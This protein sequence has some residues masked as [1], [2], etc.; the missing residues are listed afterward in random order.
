MSE[1]KYVFFDIETLSTRK[2][3][4]VLSFGATIVDPTKY[5]TFEQIVSKG[6]SIKFDAAQQTELGRHIDKE[7]LEWWSEQGNAAQRILVPN[8]DLDIKVED[9]YEELKPLGYV[10]DAYWYCKGPHFDA[11]IMESL[12]EQVGMKAP[13]GYNAIRDVRTWFECVAGKAKPFKW[14]DHKPASFVEHDALHDASYDAFQ[15][16]EI[17]HGDEVED[18]S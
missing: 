13:W 1:I 12:F 5:M 17:L 2:N 18:D 14:P 11:A 7:T 16:M 15:M 6:V 8:K 4:L 9:F 3:A 10:Q